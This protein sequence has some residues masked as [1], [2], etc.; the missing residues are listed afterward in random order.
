M[1]INFKI[2]VKALLALLK[3]VHDFIDNFHIVGEEWNL[4]HKPAILAAVAFLRKVAASVGN[5]K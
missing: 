5:P 2:K 1:Q 4:V 3:K